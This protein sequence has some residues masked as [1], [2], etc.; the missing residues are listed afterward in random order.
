MLGY[1]YPTNKYNITKTERESV[2]IV[3]M[4]STIIY[5]GIENLW[6]FV[7]AVENDRATDIPLTVLPNIL[8]SHVT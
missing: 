4:I 2:T 7:T 6:L 8:P 5:E 1:M 3:R